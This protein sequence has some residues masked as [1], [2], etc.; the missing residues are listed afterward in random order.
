MLLPPLFLC[1]TVPAAYSWGARWGARTPALGTGVGLL[2]AAFFGLVASWPRFYTGGSYDLAF[3]LP[4]FLL[5]LGL[6]PTF[7]RSKR[8][9]GSQLVGFGLLAGVLT[10]LSLAAGEGLLVVLLTFGIVTNLRSVRTLATWLGRT[11]CV[12][13]FEVA[14]TIRSLIAWITYGQPGFA[15]ATVFGGLNSRLLQGELDPFVPGKP[16]LSPFPWISLELQVLLVASVILTVWVLRTATTSAF[17]ASLSQLAADLSTGTAALCLLTGALLLSALPGPEA[18]SL[19]SF[20]NLDQSSILLFVFFGALSTFPLVMA[21]SWLTS[22]KETSVHSTPNTS[23]HRPILTLNRKG[24]RTAGTSPVIVGTVAILVLVVPLCAGAVFTVAQGPGFIQTNVG[25]TSN[26][27]ADD[28]SAMAW[29]GAHLQPCSTVLVAPGSAG[30]FLPEYANVHVALPMNPVP[31]SPPYW[32]AVSNLT[33]GEYSFVTRN[34]LE[35][36]S[37]TEVLVTGQTSVSYLPFSATP[38]L[39]STDFSLLFEAGDAY[40]FEFIPVAHSLDCGP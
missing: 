37:I 18:S 13:I 25:K 31:K 9:T 6:L 29:I 39:G 12:A 33:A 30:Q 14:F 32:T 10:S 11:A 20:T 34:A 3:A 23:I 22:G 35:N 26:V 40:V 5:A 8:V 21:L 16:K 38:L 19:R 4:L 24:S 1:L 7:V 28:V 36:L 17:R 27:S 15:P 2:F